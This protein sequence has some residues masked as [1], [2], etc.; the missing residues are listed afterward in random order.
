MEKHIPVELCMETDTRRHTKKRATPR[1]IIVLC[2]LEEVKGVC[3]PWAVF[4][5]KSSPWSWPWV[6]QWRR[7]V[8]RP[9]CSFP[10]FSLWV[11]S[12]LRW[13]SPSSSSNFSPSPCHQCCQENRDYGVHFYVQSISL[14][15]NISFVHL[16]S[17]IFYASNFYIKS[18]FD[19]LV[20]LR[21]IFNNRNSSPKI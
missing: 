6:R 5:W 8:P 12:Q 19:I 11:H 21:G 14:L 17:D 7:P 9:V 3:Q 1:N 10:V 16:F 15:K 20:I 2:K 4:Q 13:I 18:H